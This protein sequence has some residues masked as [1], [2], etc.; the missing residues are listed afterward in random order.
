MMGM[1]L[2]MCKRIVKLLGGDIRLDTTYKKGARF[3]FDIPKE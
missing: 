3:E 1:G 2:S